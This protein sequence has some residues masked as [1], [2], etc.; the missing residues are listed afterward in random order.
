MKHKL[1]EIKAPSTSSAHLNFADAI[2]TRVF[3]L[4]IIKIFT[5]CKW[6]SRLFF[7]ICTLDNY[8]HFYF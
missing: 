1:F 7:S 5:Y 3:L 4:Y 2:F 8:F 6:I